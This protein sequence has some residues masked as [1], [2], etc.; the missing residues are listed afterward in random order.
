MSARS[1]Q[2]LKFLVVLLIEAVYFKE[3]LCIIFLNIAGKEK[4]SGNLPVFFLYINLSIDVL[5]CLV[6]L[7]RGKKCYSQCSI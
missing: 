1:R 5:C 4:L 2:H 6:P 3:P 7:L